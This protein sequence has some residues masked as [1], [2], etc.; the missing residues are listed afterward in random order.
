MP[1]VGFEPAIPAI[2]R[3]HA[4]ALHIATT[5]IGFILTYFLILLLVFYS[6]TATPPL[7]PFLFSPVFFGGEGF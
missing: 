6:D 2:K 4:H 3:P 1:L 7:K 5:G